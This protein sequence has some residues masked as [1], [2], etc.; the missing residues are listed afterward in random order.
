[1]GSPATIISSDAPTADASAD[2]DPPPGVGSAE[3]NAVSRPRIDCSVNDMK[4]LR[5]KE[6]TEGTV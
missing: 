5:S 3:L 1:L 6:A 2:A 4:P